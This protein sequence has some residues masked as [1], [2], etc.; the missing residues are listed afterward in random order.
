ML[1]KSNMYE[2]Y[3]P[4]QQNM[5]KSTNFDVIDKNANL[6]EAMNDPL[7][8]DIPLTHIKKHHGEG[9]NKCYNYVNKFIFQ[10]WAIDYTNQKHD[11]L[12]EQMNILAE[13]QEKRN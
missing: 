2:T 1:L 13:R 6:S 10:F 5:T 9:V 8:S 3:P 11:E 12:L 7:K 4:V